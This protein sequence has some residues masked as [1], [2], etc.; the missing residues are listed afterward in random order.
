MSGQRKAVIVAGMHRSGTSALTRVINLLGADIALQLIPASI[1]NELGH[2]ESRAAQ[3]LHN[4]MLAELQSDIY[5]P[6]NFPASWFDSA[7]A[8]TWIDRIEALVRQ[9]YSTS[10][11]FVLKDPRLALF[12]PLWIAALGRLAIE[13]CFVLPFRNPLAVAASLEVREDQL[14]SGKALPL[15]QGAAVWLRYT[16]AA[17]QHTRGQKRS[18]VSFDRLLEDWRREVIRIGHQLDIKWPRL[19]AS[20]PEIDRFLDSDH[21]DIASAARPNE[22]FQVPQLIAR[23]FEELNQA[24]AEPQVPSPTFDQAAKTIAAA[25]EMLGAYTL[26]KEKQ[27]AQLHEELEAARRQHAVETAQAHRSFDLEIRARD[28]R[29]A[30]ATAYATTLEHSRDEALR[31][32]E[33]QELRIAEL[34]Q[35]PA[36]ARRRLWNW[37][38]SRKE[39]N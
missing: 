7:S 39:P 1:G 9:D 32:A 31:H 8:K 19:G 18:F 4:E 24:V 10:D 26:I 12:V 33:A 22:R 27:V 15:S 35:T 2:W 6:V 38:G 17:E 28:A 30:D 16:L 37:W 14:R 11:L 20:D 34:A 3:D 13:P 21:R 5:S 36:G 29:I 25:Q 23:V